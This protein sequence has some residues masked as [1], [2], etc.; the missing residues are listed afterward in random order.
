MLASPV[1][2]AKF[3]RA[4]DESPVVDDLLNVKTFSALTTY[5]LNARF[6]PDG[7]RIFAAGATVFHSVRLVR[8]G[9]QCPLII[10]SGRESLAG[11]L[12]SFCQ[13]GHAD[14]RRLAALNSLNVVGHAGLACKYVIYRRETI[15]PTE[16]K[17]C[18]QQLLAS[19][20]KPAACDRIVRHAITGSRATGL[21]GGR[22]HEPNAFHLSCPFLVVVPA[23][24][25]LSEMVLPQVR[26]F[27]DLG[28]EC[29]DD[30]YDRKVGRIHR[31]L[32][33]G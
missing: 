24:P 29:F 11:G 23:S 10:G 2:R 19:S 30:R 13:C 32:I 33:R 22:G 1:K 4:L 26:H 31:N 9:N 6:P 25:R 7:Y 15:V 18:C 28:L 5:Q 20:Q 27:M 16:L 17:L 12:Q 21:P 3:M 8:R 14:H